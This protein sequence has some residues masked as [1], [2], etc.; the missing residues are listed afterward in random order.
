LIPKTDIYWAVFLEQNLFPTVQTQKSTRSAPATTPTTPDDPFLPPIF[1]AESGAWIDFHFSQKLLEFF[2][3]ITLGNPPPRSS[4]T[5]LL[6]LSAGPTVTF[7][8]LIRMVLRLTLVMLYETDAVLHTERIA[9]KRD[10]L[11]QVEACVTANF[12]NA[13]GN[14][15]GGGQ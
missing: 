13:A 15:L 5:N 2:D 11:Q 14:F 6:P 3:Q 10:N 12:G 4:Q 9:K 1:R 7:S 8:T